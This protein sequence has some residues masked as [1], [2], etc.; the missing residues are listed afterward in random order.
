MPELS[1]A[2]EEAAANADLGLPVP[3]ATRF[4]TL[5]RLFARASWLFLRQQVKVNRAVIAEASELRRLLE[6]LRAEVADLA[7]GLDAMAGKLAVVDRQ[8]VVRTADHVDLVRRELDTL[9]E[10]VLQADER[11][12]ELGRSQ[13]VLR[14]ALAGVPG[15]PGRVRR[16]DEAEASVA[17]AASGP[18]PRRIGGTPTSHLE[19]V[20]AGVGRFDELFRGP[21]A[22]ISGR[23]E[24]YLRDLTAAGI[25]EGER[26][27]DLGSGRGEWLALLEKAGFLATGVESRAELAEECR[28]RGLDVVTADALDYLSRAPA[29]S[30]AA[31]SAYHF[32]EHLD[33][34]ALVHLLELSHQALRPNGL[35]LL[36]TPNPENVLVGASHFYYDPTHTRPIPPRLLAFVVEQAGFDGVAVRELHPVG[37]LPAPTGEG[38]QRALEAVVDLL[39]RHLLGPQDYA[40]L[41]RRR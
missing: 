13:V 10:R 20:F 39:N 34:T 1:A 36:E 29:G 7:V 5:K 4:Y 38:D 28:E 3:R 32:V 26:V 24:P 18:S 16:G 25:R 19:E 8:A 41:A 15:W 37:S 17:G 14:S 2:L 40:V 23:L 21:A 6:D 27:V 22:E 12:G 35:L 30:I 11:L 33:M 9:W 31:I